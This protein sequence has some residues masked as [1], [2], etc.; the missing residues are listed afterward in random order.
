MMAKKRAR[1]KQKEERAR[2]RR[3]G[4]KPGREFEIAV[5]EF[6]KTLADKDTKV[7]FDHKQPSVFNGK[8]RQ[9]DAWIRTKVLGHVP[10]TIAVS[11]KDYGRRLDETHIEDFHAR[12]ESYGASTGIIYSRKG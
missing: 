12:I 3:A 7:D 5:Y 6:V 10:I 8:M 11:C 4:K 1:E 9:V 2:E